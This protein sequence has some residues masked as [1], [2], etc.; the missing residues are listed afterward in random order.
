M[1]VAGILAACSGQATPPQALQVTLP[2]TVNS[3]PVYTPTATRTPSLT[4]TLTATASDT[5]TPTTPPTVTPSPTASASASPTASVTSTSSPTATASPVPTQA[6]YTLTPASALGA[7]PAITLEPA[8]FSAETGWSCGAFPCEEDIAGFLRK[9][10]VPAGFAVSHVGQLPGQPQQITYG[11]DGRLYATIGGGNTQAGAVAVL[12]PQTGVSAIY[13]DGLIAPVGL[14]FQPGSD[15]LYVSVRRAPESGGAVVRIAEGGGAAAVVVDDLPCCWREID[16]QVNGMTFGADGLLYVGVSALSDHGESPDPERQA[17]RDPLPFEASVLRMNPHTGAYEVYAEG[18]RHPFDV[19]FTSERIGY[20][21]DSG[22]LGGAVDRLLQLQ[23][24]G[25]YQFPYWRAFGCAE[26]P[27]TRN[28]IDYAPTLLT[29]PDYSLP[30][31]ITAYTGSQFPANLFDNLF[32]AVWHDNGF[33]QRIVRVDPAAIPADP[34]LRAAYTPLPF[35][36]G[37][38]RPIDV[39]LAP[40]GALVIADAIYGHVW[41]VDYSGR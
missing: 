8:G 23:A 7:P 9:I 3:A 40:D 17:Y 30:R 22:T 26:C 31:G 25:H 5:P 37:L 28:D 41:R 11:R 16:N 2:P 35:V 38:M 13:A 6:L 14:A 36:T 29:F 18:I 15:V 27:P 39:T 4:P 12:D 32:V 24:G 19:A 20:A 1:I 33:G 21:T 10:Q 34:E